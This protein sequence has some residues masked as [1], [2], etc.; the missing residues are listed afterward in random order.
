MNIVKHWKVAAAAVTFSGMPSLA[1]AADANLQPD[2]FVGISL[3]DFNGPG[4]VDR[5]LLYRTRPR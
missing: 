2:D 4:G 1:I 3:V 5:F